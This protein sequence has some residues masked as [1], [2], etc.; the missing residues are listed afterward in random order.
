MSDRIFLLNNGVVQQSG[1]PDDIY[2]RPANPFVADFLGKVDFFRGTAEGGQLLL[3]DWG[4]SLPCPASARSGAV[5]AAV[6]PENIRMHKAGGTGVPGVLERLYYLG[7]VTD[8]RV[9]VGGILVRVI[10]DADARLTC[11][12]G[13]TVALEVKDFMVFPDDGSTAEQLKI[14]T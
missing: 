3:T 4:A 10:A 2:N 9:K 5:I 14:R 1:T 7:D 13:E 12:P 11:K 6:R 8:C